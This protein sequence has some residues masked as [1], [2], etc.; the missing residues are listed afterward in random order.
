MQEP[1]LTGVALAR[2]RGIG[3]IQGFNVPATVVRHRSDGITPLGDEIP[4][5]L[6]RV[7]VAGVAAG[8]SHDRDGL[9]STG[10]RQVEPTP[11]LVQIGRHPLEVVAQL[12]LVG[13]QSLTISRRL[14]VAVRVIAGNGLLFG[15]QLP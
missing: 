6:R 7:H 9:V 3:V 12:L 8:H 13:H 5:S 2:R 4:Q 14:R 11:G 15:P 1:T 10:L